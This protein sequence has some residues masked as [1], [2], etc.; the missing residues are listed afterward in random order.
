MKQ[1]RKQ[2]S[3]PAHNSKIKKILLLQNLSFR[4]LTKLLSE[5][6]L[7]REFLR[8]KRDCKVQMKSL[9]QIA[10]KSWFRF[11]VSRQN[12]IKTSEIWKF[13][14][15][16]TSAKIS[17]PPSPRFYLNQASSYLLVNAKHSLK[18]NSLS[19]THFSPNKVSMDLLS[20][21]ARLTSRLKVTGRAK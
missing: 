19:T 10:W 16:L 8:E 2:A 14:L 7:T 18:S 4:L 20:Q 9:K 17:M 15:S 11:S 3:M 21:C 1:M 5:K 6:G 12:S 13:G